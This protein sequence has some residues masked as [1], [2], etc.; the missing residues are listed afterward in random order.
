MYIHH[1]FNDHDTVVDNL[2]RE[3]VRETLE[4]VESPRQW[5]WAL[6]DYGVYLKK[7]VGNLNKLSNTYT[8]QTTF[9]GSKRQL[10][11]AILRML[12]NGPYTKEE[13][14]ASLHDDRLKEVLGSLLVEKMIQ[15]SGDK[16]S[17]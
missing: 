1:F 12:S 4:G 6:M 3:K 11:G 9:H 8:R 17:L 16:Y 14:E 15:Y 13:L 7:T 5:Y 2:I 10:R